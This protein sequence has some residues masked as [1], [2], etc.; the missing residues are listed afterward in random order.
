MEPISRVIDGDIF[1]AAMANEAHQFPITRSQRVTFLLSAMLSKTERTLLEYVYAAHL[2][3]TSAM[4]EVDIGGFVMLVPSSFETFG[5]TVQGTASVELYWGPDIAPG[6][7]FQAALHISPGQPGTSA[8]IT[9]QGPIMDNNGSTGLGLTVANFSQD[10]VNGV[11]SPVE[12]SVNI[13]SA[14]AHGL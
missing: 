1:V 7:W 10:F 5:N 4:A 8:G 11:S 9:Q 3:R 13:L 2:K 12:V 6:Q 14:P